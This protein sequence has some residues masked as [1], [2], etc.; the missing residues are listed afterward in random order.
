MIL[1]NHNEKR[2]FCKNFIHR[3]NFPL[4]VLTA[5]ADK[6]LFG[7]N[8]FPLIFASALSCCIAA[9]ASARQFAILLSVRK[10]LHFLQISFV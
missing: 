9:V 8:N 5:W 10:I 4:P 7:K 3:N 1:V 6:R 2:Y